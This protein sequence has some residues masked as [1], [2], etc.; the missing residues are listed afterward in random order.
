MNY[1]NAV[2]FIDRYL[3]ERGIEGLRELLQHISV[4]M[5][6][7]KEWQNKFNYSATNTRTRSNS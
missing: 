1:L 3:N 5:T 6:D 4:F 7:N 2:D